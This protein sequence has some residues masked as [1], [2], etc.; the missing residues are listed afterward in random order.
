MTDELKPCPF[1]DSS[2]I[3]CTFWASDS[4]IRSGPGCSKCGAKAESDELWNT[5]APT[6]KEVHLTGVVNSLIGY[7]SDCQITNQNEWMNRLA[8]R[9]NHALQLIGCDDRIAR[10]GEGFQVI[11]PE[12]CNEN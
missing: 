5:R 3:D 7:M 10:H 2:D 8:A 6:Q 9:L 12:D 11:T 1:C 4:G